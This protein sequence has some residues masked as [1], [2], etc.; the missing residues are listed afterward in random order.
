LY[1]KSIFHRKGRIFQLDFEIDLRNYIKYKETEED[2]DILKFDG[3]NQRRENLSAIEIESILKSI[4][5]TDES[6]LKNVL[7]KVKSTL[8]IVSTDDK[9]IAIIMINKS[10]PDMLNIFMK[11]EDSV[12]NNQCCLALFIRKRLDL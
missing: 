5:V 12:K 3:K 9:K 6:F 1:N 7:S 2:L 10:G 4:L 8:Q 11:M